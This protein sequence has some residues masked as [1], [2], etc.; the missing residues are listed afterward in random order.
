[1]YQTLRGPLA[2]QHGA[3]VGYDGVGPAIGKMFAVLV[4]DGEAVGTVGRSEPQNVSPEGGPE[5]RIIRVAGERYVG[6]RPAERPIILRERE[7]KDG[8]R[9][10][11]DSCP[12]LADRYLRSR[13]IGETDNGSIHIA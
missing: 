9:G 12:V 10:Q 7:L 13:R 6:T 2:T 5:R 4:H 3:L 11:R 8:S 1:M